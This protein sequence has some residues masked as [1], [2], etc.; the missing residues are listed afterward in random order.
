MRQFYDSV[1]TALHQPGKN[2][3]QVHRSRPN[4][5]F[6][7]SFD[8]TY[9]RWHFVEQETTPTLAGV[10]LRVQNMVL[11]QDS[12]DIVLS[13]GIAIGSDFRVVAS[14]PWPVRPKWDLC[15]S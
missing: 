2:G 15:E 6:C 13:V 1:F 12:N 3:R 7:K 11:A 8:V 14:F 5:V 4:L 10:G 9:L